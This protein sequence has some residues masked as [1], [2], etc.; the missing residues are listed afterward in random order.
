MKKIIAL[1][2]ALC[3]CLRLLS[4]C[5]GN[6]DVKD[7]SQPESPSQSAPS[8]NPDVT[9]EEPS[10]DPS[11][12]PEAPTQEP[13]E[14]PETPSEAPSAEPSAILAEP[15]EPQFTL[16]QSDFT[17][18]NPNDSWTLTYTADPVYK[19]RPV[20]TSSDESVATVDENGVVTAIG[21]GKA[22]ITATY[23]ES[24]KAS[25]IVRCRWKESE[26]TESDVPADAT[27]SGVD[28]S[29]FADTLFGKYEFSNSM[30]LADAEVTEAFYA[31]LSAVDGNQL[32][33]YVPQ[34][35]MNM[36]ELVLVEVR[37]GA[38]VDAIKAILQARI[39]YMAGDGTGP[40]GA[41]YPEAT[42][43]WMYNSRVVS[44]GNYVMM[45]VH[46]NCDDIV[47][48]FNALF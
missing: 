30:I 2:S 42:D 20:F 34:M 40:G 9:P 11:E 17:L 22:V 3:L 44:S 43:T 32:L 8:E 15:E 47:S 18:F 41:W 6:A 21:P 25:C 38:D 36:G 35:S 12:I 37:E 27:V 5:G 24:G 46:D 29:T 39:D 7:S 4:A 19:E 23:G 48:D 28:L 1:L 31:G 14:N 16:D 33:V 13:S 26:P 10:A 45:V